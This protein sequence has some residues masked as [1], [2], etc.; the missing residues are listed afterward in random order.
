MNQDKKSSMFI[1]FRVF[2][3]STSPSHHPPSLS[4]SLSLCKVGGASRYR[5]LISREV[6]TLKIQRRKHVGSHDHHHHHRQ[7]CHHH[8]RLCCH[9][10]YL[11]LVS[12]LR[13]R[14]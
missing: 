4:L 14:E 7:H 6:L 9:D 2:F 5:F 3:A 10:H 13:S 12:C 8:H 11:C 1:S